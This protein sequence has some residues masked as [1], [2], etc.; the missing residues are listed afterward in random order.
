MGF[1]LNEAPTSLDELFVYVVHLY[2]Y[3]STTLLREL[4]LHHGQP[5]ILALLWDNDGLK[6]KEIAEAL[7]FQPA[8]IT[9]MIQRMEKAG[10]VFRK[11]DTA[12]LRVT[13]IYLTD[14]GRDVKEE[15]EVRVKQ[16]ENE[17]FADFSDVE[18]AL[19]KR[20]FKQMYNNLVDF[21]EEDCNNC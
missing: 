19:I 21:Y 7:H 20:F 12:D 18:I 3:R 6:Q 5:R 17:T 10:F 13:R 4:G 11:Q 1:N 15:I 16:L 2:R 9:R 14:C 8:T